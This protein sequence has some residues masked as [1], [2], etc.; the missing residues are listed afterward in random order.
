MH[1]KTTVQLEVI[2]RQILFPLSS[3]CLYAQNGGK[4]V[5]GELRHAGSQPGLLRVGPT[6]TLLF[7]VCYFKGQEAL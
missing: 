3:K 2:A 1:H 5:E 7:E 4:K 6:G